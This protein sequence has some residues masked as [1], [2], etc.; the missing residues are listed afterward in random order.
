MGFLG[1]LTGDGS[2]TACGRHRG[3]CICD[4]SVRVTTKGLKPV[5]PRNPAP[6]RK[7]AKSG[8]HPCT[9]LCQ[10][11]GRTKTVCGATIRGGVCPCPDC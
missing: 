8:P 7:A 5:K 2:C 9:Q 1:R 3:A 11:R 10:V 6:P 4:R